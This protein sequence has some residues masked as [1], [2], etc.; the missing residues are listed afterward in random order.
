MSIALLGSRETCSAMLERQ[1]LAQMKT[2]LGSSAVLGSS[3][4][5]PACAGAAEAKS[6]RT[7]RSWVA[8]AAKR[9]FG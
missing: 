8:T 3:L 9:P 4:I 6:Q 1:L 2:V 5:P 7:T